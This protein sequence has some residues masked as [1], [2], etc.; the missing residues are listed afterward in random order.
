MWITNGRSEEEKSALHELRK[1]SDRT[2][3]ILGAA[4]LDIRLRDSIQTML[5]P[6]ANVDHLL[7]K[8]GA[9]LKD[10]GARVNIAYAFGFFGPKCYSDL[11]ILGKIRNKFA[12]KFDGMSFA[13]PAIRDACDALWLPKNLNELEGANGWNWERESIPNAGRDQFEFA[14]RFLNAGLLTEPKERSI[15]SPMQIKESTCLRW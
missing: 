1:G 13:T 15:R 8:Q 4:L 5:L 9:P 7:D 2:C 12:H 10:F 14:L 11:K 6:A 3:V